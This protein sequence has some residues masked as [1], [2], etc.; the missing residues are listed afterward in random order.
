MTALAI[1]F[2]YGPDRHLPKWRWVTWGVAPAGIGW[3]AVSLGLSWYVTELDFDNRPAPRGASH[4]RARAA[5]DASIE[6]RGTITLV[7]RTSAENAVSAERAVIEAP[8]IL[9]PT[10]TTAG[11]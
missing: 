5:E 3:V 9:P 1:L 2:R 8:S 10:R 6:R 4:R 11:T 7:R